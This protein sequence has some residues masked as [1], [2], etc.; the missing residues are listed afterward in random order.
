MNKVL[1]YIALFIVLTAISLLMGAL[2]GEMGIV[3][4]FLV[5]LSFI[6]TWAICRVADRFL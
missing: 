2:I 3:A 4:F 1:D 5:L 6:L